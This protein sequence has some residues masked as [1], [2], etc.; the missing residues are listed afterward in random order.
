MNIIISTNFRKLD[1]FTRACLLQLL[2]QPNPLCLLLLTFPRSFHQVVLQKAEQQH[3]V[4]A[5]CIPGQ[6][7]CLGTLGIRIGPLKTFNF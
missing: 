3:Q 7:S 2:R 6:S 1:W 4:I 5:H